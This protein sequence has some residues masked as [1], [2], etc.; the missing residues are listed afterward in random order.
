MAVDI[1]SLVRGY[2]YVQGVID[3]DIVAG[4]Y[5]KLAC[6]RFLEDLET[7]Q[8]FT[9]EWPWEFDALQAAR[10]VN[11]IERVCKHSRGTFAGKPF[12][13]SPWQ[14]FFVMQIFGW[15]DHNDPSRRRF[16]T[17]HLFVARKSG[18]SQLAAA[19]TL[20]MAVLDDDGAPQLVS[21]ATKK[22][23][24][25][26][27]WDEVVRTIKQS[28]ALRKRFTPQRNVV[29]G[30]KNGT[31]KPLSSDANSLDGLNLNLAVVDEFHAMKTGDLYRVLASSMGS[32]KS[33][34]M[35]AITT[36]GFLPDGPCANFMAQGKKV[37][38][39]TLT[40]DRLLILTY[41]IDDPELWDDPEE[42]KKAN[43]G[44][45]VSISEEFLLAQATNARMY[46]PQSVNEFK[47]KH[48]NLF[49]G[50]A[51]VWISDEDWMDER[52]LLEPPKGSMN[53]RT[54]KEE[55]YIGLD[56]A[57]TDDISAVAVIKGNNE[58]GWGLD[59]QYFLPERAIE[60]RLAKDETSVYAGFADN[61]KVTVTKGNVTDYAAIRKHISGYY[62][63]GDKTAYDENCIAEKYHIVSLAYDRWNSLNLIQQLDDDGIPTDGF[64]QGFAQMSFP[65]KE[66]EKCV[67]D[68]KMAHGG[69]EVLRWM[70]GNVT[71]QIDPAGNIKPDKSKSGDKIDGAVASIMALGEALRFEDDEEQAYEF[72][73]AVVDRPGL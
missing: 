58:D 1:S 7:S 4:K 2:E 67:L 37:L 51:D 25:K 64:G 69:D 72:F 8:E 45:G 12:I 13:L 3:G 17:A 22:D 23:Q 36:A 19:I 48:C 42:L 50:S 56:L 15:V 14:V 26:E 60:R 33:P 73:M 30:P 40:N 46:G 52:N 35:L 44:L 59:V 70:M 24:A 27:V 20:A 65:S 11:F 21:A 18:K 54:E 10:Y 9:D 32:R 29:H 38:D 28:S 68:G 55:V 41:E 66:F 34:L 49:M 53:K 63:D 39:K 43:P 57:S 62:R 6:E 16:T 47:V 61:P 31:I 5:I 71:L